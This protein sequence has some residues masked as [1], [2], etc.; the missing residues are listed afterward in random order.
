MTSEGPRP[1][2]MKAVAFV[3]VGLV[4]VVAA[5]TIALTG[6]SEELGREARYSVWI[7]ASLLVAAV[8]L[9][10]IVKAVEAKGPLLAITLSVVGLGVVSAGVATVLFVSGS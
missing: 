6:F 8:A 5:V 2:T 7:L 10:Q 3:L 4:A 9:T 1:Q